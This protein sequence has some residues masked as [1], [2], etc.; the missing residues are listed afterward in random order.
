VGAAVVHGVA[1]KRGGPG[2]G[3][4]VGVGQ[5]SYSNGQE[6]RSV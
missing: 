3:V 2:V 6:A 5:G 1:S 4:G